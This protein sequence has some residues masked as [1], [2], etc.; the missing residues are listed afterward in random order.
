MA[1]ANTLRVPTTECITLFCTLG[2]A[3]AAGASQK[4]Y[5][6]PAGDDANPGT[7][8]KPF[9]ALSRARDAA[10][11]VSREMTGDIV[12]CLR[13]GTHRVT[14]PVEFTA[15]DSGRNDF[16]IIY[17]SYREET[18]VISGGISVTDWSVHKGRITKRRFGRIAVRTSTG[19]AT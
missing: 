2:A 6:S 13:G 17:R 3:F 18:P 15:A 5:V 16:H 1:L 11:V 7:L 9:Q 4:F 12:V 19:F 8:A 14:A 10:R